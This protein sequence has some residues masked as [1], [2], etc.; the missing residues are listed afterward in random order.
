MDKILKRYVFRLIVFGLSFY[1]ISHADYHY[2]SHSGSNT[3]P[4]TSWEMAADSIQK[5]INATDPHDTVFISSGDWVEHVAVQDFDSIGFV[6]MGIDSTFWTS[7]NQTVEILT[8]DY[9][10]SVSDITFHDFN[11]ICIRARALAG[12]EIARCN[13]MRS[14]VGI[15]V[16]GGPSSITKCYIDSC[17]DGISLPLSDGSYYIANNLITNS[18]GNWDIYLQAE[19]ALIEKNI[20][21]NDPHNNRGMCSICGAPG[22]S[23]IR[24][25]YI[26]NTTIGFDNADYGYNNILLNFNI[27]GD[28]TAMGAADG[29]I[30]FN[31]ISA[32]NRRGISLVGDGITVKYNDFWNNRIDI[33]DW[34]NLYDSV[35]NIFQN[36]MLLNSDS[37]DYHLQA[38]SPLIDAGDPTVF[39]PD[40]SRSDIGLYGGPLGEVYAY[41]DL[42]PASPDSLRYS[43]IGDSLI[44]NWRQNSE[45]D[46]FRYIVNRDTISGFTPWAGNIVAEPETSFFIDLHWDRS[47]NYY[48]RIAAYDNQGNLSQYSAELAVINVGVFGEPLYLPTT[49]Y[50]ESNYPNPFNSGTAIVYYVADLGPTPA[51][52]EI[53][54]YDIMGRQIR[55]LLGSREDVGEHRVIWDC[56]DDSG[57]DLPSG[58]Y[59][60][61]ISQWGISIL[62]HP[63]KLVLVR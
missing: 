47:H 10:C 43:I 52:I 51:Q 17:S 62:N 5:A 29:S 27:G 6:G 16:D 20:I 35:G 45:A 50:I 63:R 42:P 48:Y 19:S 13:F 8:I 1:S 36:P 53:T 18:Y 40:S 58:I 14:Y 39:D 32:N 59:F 24:N 54:I 21:I 28:A 44:I 4:Y 33:E 12:I 3:Y 46:F 61:K 7:T 25:N 22:Y 2:A 57:H 38:F 41:Q 23:V 34:G 15:Q 56:R 55:S 37:G 11:F 30:N 31:N 26:A 60:A 9:G 49:T